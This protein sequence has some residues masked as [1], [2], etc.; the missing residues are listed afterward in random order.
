VYGC[1]CVITNVSS[2]MQAVDAL[3]HLP[4]G[5]VPVS[6][7]KVL[8]TTTH[9]LSPFS[10][11]RL[12]FAFYM[13]R[14]GIF[15]HF[16]V[17]VSKAGGAEAGEGGAL[18]AFAAPTR[19]CA[20]EDSVAG[21]DKASWL[22]VSQMG[23]LQEV[24]AY[25]AACNHKQTD[26][27]RV[28]WRCK[29]SDA[30][31]RAI[32]GA[33]RARHLYNADVWAYSLRHRDVPTARE[34]LA[35]DEISQ[36]LASYLGPFPLLS[37]CLL[38]TPGEPWVAEEDAAAG[39]NA[40]DAAAATMPPLQANRGMWLNV[41]NGDLPS[42]AYEHLEYS[43]LVN[44]RAH[45]L[46]EK[47][48]IVNKAVLRQWRSLLAVLAAKAPAA[49][50]AA[51][52]LA[53]VYFLLLMDRVPEAMTLFAAVPPPADS[54]AART[55]ATAG[56]AAGAGAASSLAVLAAGRPG[57]WLGLQYDYCAAYLDLYT[58]PVEDEAPLPGTAFPVATAVAA[59]YAAYP[60]PKWAA[61][62]AEVGTLLAQLRALASGSAVA[63][64][65][66]PAALGSG[67]SAEETGV[68]RELGREQQQARAAAAEP[69]LAVRTRGAAV[70]VGAANLP[71]AVLSFYAMDV[72]L[73]F[74]NTPFAIAASAGS[75]K[76]GSLGAMGQFAFVRPNSTVALPLGTAAGA[77]TLGGGGLSEVAYALPPSLAK[78]NMLVVA[79]HGS[80]RAIT[81]F[82]AN[83][84]SVTLSEGFGRLRVTHASTGA[85]LPRVYVKVY[86]RGSEG[87][88]GAFYK[89]GYTTV[90][91]AFDYAALSTDE[92][93][94]TQ[95]F[96]ILVMSEEHGAVVLTAAPPRA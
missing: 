51:D 91:G 50:T 28:L 5:A 58:G 20:V 27:S 10:T 56:A 70:V 32:V 87:E 62:F 29:E 3:V 45:M 95:R 16:P 33:L 30:D 80:L 41:E 36:R 81:P 82:F 49:V 64:R 74:S 14:A 42:Y 61:K 31:Y 76:G 77:S 4:Q 53:A 71:R 46:G 52:Q 44:A 60:V 72:E 6:G 96:A 38:T 7:H 86:W 18:L 54:V 92:L 94:R 63:A 35:S 39:G 75:S 57:N 73:L 8:R 34:Y 43:P 23:T 67:A 2:Q 55:R 83:D 68:S 9:R 17:H 65:E 19:I 1:A 25:L 93:A 88:S 12:E 22:W 85:P 79:S 69:Q 24:V 47:R 11:E 13:P 40:A 37:S 48:Q 59:A 78:R 15:E 89:D 84:L 26:I 90:G 21:I 66:A